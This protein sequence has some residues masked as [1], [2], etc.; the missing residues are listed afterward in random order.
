MLILDSFN[1]IT[2]HDDPTAARTYLPWF[3][4]FVCARREV[5]VLEHLQ[6]N[7][8]ETLLPLYST[9]RRWS[10]RVKEVVVPL[11]PG[12]LFCR[13]DPQKRLPILKT[14]SVIQ[15]VGCNRSPVPV[16]DSE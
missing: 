9:R 11:F 5:S 2:R 16:R 15:I 6:A 14:P 1:S 7:G 12:Y 10:D 8:Y 4:L 3:A 13:F